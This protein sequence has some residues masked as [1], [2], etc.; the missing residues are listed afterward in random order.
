MFA[1]NDTELKGELLHNIA[2]AQFDCNESTKPY[3][4]MNIFSRLIRKMRLPQENSVVLAL[5]TNNKDQ[6]LQQEKLLKDMTYATQPCGPP[7]ASR[8]LLPREVSISVVS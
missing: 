4:A 6:L 2:I 5:I 7:L 3:P 1:G 8:K